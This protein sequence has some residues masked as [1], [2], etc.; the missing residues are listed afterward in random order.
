MKKKTSMQLLKELSEALN[1]ASGAAT[2]LIQA[3][4]NAPGFFVIRDALELSREGILEVAAKSS[5][6]APVR[7]H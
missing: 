1:Q 6:I 4:G 2:G 5:I 7:M 3:S